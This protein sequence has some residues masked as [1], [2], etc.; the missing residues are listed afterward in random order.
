MFR[1][2]CSFAKRHVHAITR[3]NYLADARLSALTEVVLLHL[4]CGVVAKADDA[5]FKA[6][7]STKEI[8]AVARARGEE[9]WGALPPASPER[10]ALLVGT[11]RE[12]ANVS[13]L[14]LRAVAAAGDVN[15]IRSSLRTVAL[16]NDGQLFEVAERCVCTGLWRELQ[17]EFAEAAGRI[18]V[19]LNVPPGWLSFLTLGN[20][21]PP[22]VRL[23][24]SALFANIAVISDSFCENW[25]RLQYVGSTLA[26]PQNGICLII[27]HRSL[28]G[29]L[30]GCSGLT[31][32]DLTPLAL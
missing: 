15:L 20:G 7:V 14:S 32:L 21:T 22:G 4:L 6:A 24:V 28:D 23:D 1:L 18:A 16:R 9:L 11:L 25:R 27:A 17:D 26:D 19:P 30:F 5:F 13:R 8:E 12:Y 2:T 3:G 31:A 10:H 29:F